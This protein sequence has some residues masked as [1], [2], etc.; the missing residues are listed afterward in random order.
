MLRG[1]A[2]R[3]RVLAVRVVSRTA[4][5]LRRVLGAPDYEAYAAHQRRHN[6]GCA[7]MT[8]REFMDSRLAQRYERPGAKCC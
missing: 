3:W 2:V 5:V 6:P 1:R 7:L 4:A 8:R